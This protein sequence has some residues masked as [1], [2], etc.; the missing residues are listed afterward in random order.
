MEKI[1]RKQY[2]K[3]PLEASLIRDGDSDDEDPEV[4][5]FTKTLNSTLALLKV[6]Q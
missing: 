4:T 5:A 6:S 3:D 2:P 1:F